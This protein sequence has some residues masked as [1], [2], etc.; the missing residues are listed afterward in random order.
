MRRQNESASERERSEAISQERRS[1]KERC[2]H[3][4]RL[5]SQRTWKQFCNARSYQSRSKG[6]SLLQ[7]QQSRPKMSWAER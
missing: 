3:D 7:L 1:L 2:N 6:Y 4:M 5:S